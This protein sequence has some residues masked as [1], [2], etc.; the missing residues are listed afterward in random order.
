M[1]FLD[2][3]KIYI[4]S[5]KGGRGC[6]SFRRE[7]YIEFGGPNGGNGG[8]GGNVIF[9]T[10]PNL[11][12]LIDFRYQQHFKA[13]KGRDGKGKNQTG[14]AGE[15]L[16]IKV[17]PGTEIYDEDKTVL[18]AD[19]IKQGQKVT[20]AN[21]GKGGLGNTYFKSSTNQAPRRFT[22][23]G[24]LEEKHLWLSLKLFADVGIIGKPNAGKSTLLSKL[25]EATPKIAD[26]PFTTLHPNLGVL[27]Q[28]DKELVLADIPGLIEGA[29]EGKGLGY[30]FLAH[31]ERCK[32]L[33]HIL[34]CS[35]DNIINNY[36]TVQNELKRYGK[37]L[38]EK[39]EL[40]AI[41]KVD[42]IRDKK[43]EILELIEKKI[44]TKPMIFS[45]FSKDG[46]EDLITV[47]F[48]HCTETND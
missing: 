19:L 17:P 36:F 2:Q 5:G 40:I 37:N 39:T 13:K 47:L 27:R 30:Q 24:N 9:V 16:I 7:K 10:D 3:A 29:H 11:N 6:V 18:L 21:G 32:V 35:D 34:D 31:I 41:S 42:L 43:E 4:A 8:K 33:L 20:L 22:Y 25:S 23:G 26:Y 1:K 48:S 38:N 45:S 46:L 14:A 12:T 15:D 44:G 28:F